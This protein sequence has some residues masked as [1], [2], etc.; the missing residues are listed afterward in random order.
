[1]YNAVNGASTAWWEDEISG[2]PS[3]LEEFVV[4]LL[5]SGFRPENCPILLSK[6]YEV[7]KRCLKSQIDRYRIPVEKSCEAFI[8][9]GE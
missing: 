8:I 5:K 4:A 1:M 6:L 2:C 9:P 7:L 3:S